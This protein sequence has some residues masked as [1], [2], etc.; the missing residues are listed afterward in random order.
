MAY[1][2]DQKYGITGYFE[3]ISKPAFQSLWLDLYSFLNFSSVFI[4]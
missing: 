4:H 3:K 1:E 2:V